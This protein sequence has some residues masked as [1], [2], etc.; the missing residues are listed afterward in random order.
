MGWPWLFHVHLFILSMICI[1]ASS[2]ESIELLKLCETSEDI[3][4]A[5]TSHDSDQSLAISISYGDI[6]GVSSNILTAETW[7]RTNGLA[8]YPAVRI[9]TIVINLDL[10][11]RGGDHKNHERKLNL[12]LPSL[13]NMYHSLK[14]WGLENDIKVSVS[15]PLDCFPIHSLRHLKMVKYNLKP[16]LEFLQSVNSTYSLIPHSGFSH[17]SH[18]SLNLVSSHLDSIK[19][20]GFSNLKK[21]NVLGIASKIRKLSEISEPPIMESENYPFLDGYVTTRASFTPTYA[22]LLSPSPSPSANP[23]NTLPP[24][25]PIEHHGSPEAAELD[26]M[27]KSWCVAKP[28]VPALKLQQ[29]LEYACG[30]GGADCKEILPMGKCYNP[31]SVV[32]HASYAFNS[33]WQKYKRNG[34]TCYF[35]G[36]AML[37]N[38]DPSFLHCRFILS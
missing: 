29:A 3:L 15:F 27:Q 35:G 28:S 36:T 33:Y 2:E 6:N 23:L 9:T 38:S 26:Q 17:F 19:K 8:H 12:V 37:V 13:K 16:I 32:A 25:K 31:D 21:V 18:Q 30:E 7:L 5:S 1:S 11:Q 34:G 4:Q 14:R 10:C 20:L 22:P 24:C